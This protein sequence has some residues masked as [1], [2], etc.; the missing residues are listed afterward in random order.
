MSAPAG[1]VGLTLGRDLGDLSAVET[2]DDLKHIVA[3][4]IEVAIANGWTSPARA[5]DTV[6]QNVIYTAG[7]FYGGKPSDPANP[8]LLLAAAGGTVIVQEEGVALASPTG[9]LNFIGASVTAVL[10]GAVADITVVGGSSN[11][12]ETI[13]CPAGTDPVATSATDILNLTAT[14]IIV[15]TGTSGTDTINFE[16]LAYGTVQE[17]GSNIAQ[18]ATLNF[19]T[20]L[21][22]TDDAGNSRTDVNLALVAGTYIDVSGATIN[23][24]LTEVSGYSGASNQILK[25]STGTIEW[26]SGGGGS[27]YDTIQEEGVAVTQRTTLNFI[28]ATVT[29]ADDGVDTTNVTIASSIPGAVR[30]LIE[31]DVSAATWSSASNTLTPVTFIANILEHVAGTQTFEKSGSTVRVISYMT[32]PIEVG[33]GKGRIALGVPVLG[34]PFDQ[35]TF[36]A[37]TPDVTV[38]MLNVDCREVTV[39]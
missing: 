28:G 14:G 12:F 15:I 18:R 11:S 36:D 35:T 16:V 19:A 37:L 17:D 31:S 6:Y 33:A 25:N 7:N 30:F 23:V 21:T 5:G 3:N 1:S 13:N 20:G 29:A 10:N 26:G 38:E 4:L 39:T 2:L 8:D 22:A 9:T 27:G 32:T 24:D 34:E